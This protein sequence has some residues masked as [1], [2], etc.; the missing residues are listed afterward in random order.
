[1]K[2]IIVRILITVAGGLTFGL[3]AQAQSTQYRANV[4][5]DFSAGN[6]RYAAGTYSV[7]PATQ[8]NDAIMLLERKTGKARV[9]GL[10]TPGN[11]GGITGKMIFRRIGDRYVLSEVATPT[12]GL[13]IR[14]TS[15]RAEVASLEKAGE[16]VEVTLN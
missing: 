16:I 2:N 5:F 11:V 13:R 15:R 3:S 7:G 8:S 10:N 12:F 6:K 14:A 1:M 9:L 4:P